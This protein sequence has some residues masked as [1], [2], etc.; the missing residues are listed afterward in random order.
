M[1]GSALPREFWLV[2]R[3]RAFV[4]WLL[5]TL[6]LAGFAVWSGS[7]EVGQQLELVHELTRADDE[8]RRTTF[9]QQSDWGSA[10]YYTFHFTHEPPSELAFAA[11]GQ[12]DSMPWKHRV[13]MLALE[14]QI[15]ESDLSNPAIALL[16]RF[17]F[18]FFAAL[19]L[20]VI[21]IAGLIDLR[22]GERDAGR[23]ELL[24][25]TAAS[26]AA[27]W[28]LRGGLRLLLI[29]L[30]ALL[31]LWIGGIVN[32]AGA[33]PVLLASGVVLL[34]A[35]FW[36]LLAMTVGSRQQPAV[37][38]LIGMIA[39]W[40][41]FALVVPSTAR[42]AIDR[43][44]ELPALA[45]IALTQRETV[46]D[47]WD[48]P[49]EATMTRFVERYPEWEHSAEISRPFEW[50]W[51]YAFQQ[52]GDQS[53]EEIS[54]ALR[55]G[56]RKRDRYAGWAA[57]LSPPALVERTLQRLA[58]T[59]AVSLLEYEEKVRDFHRQLREFHYPRLFEDASFDPAGIDQLPRFD[60]SAAN[61]P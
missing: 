25:A 35:A 24:E 57:L 4:A 59:D 23:L 10:A 27:L 41:V 2:L 13:R 34:H 8:D 60:A 21:L 55:Q 47:A 38:L 56:R 11:L 54:E 32:G 58:G 17:D 9:G 6:L 45:D 44:V 20:P 40:L 50:K 26:A 22:A 46:N 1:S 49:K 14:G 30:A 43:M 3:D 7:R 28:R 39:A 61:A 31:P 42:V 33:L 37:V 19:L 29:C 18:A 52:V 12:R 16:G 48:L 5:A 15:Y 53:V 51:Y 36:G